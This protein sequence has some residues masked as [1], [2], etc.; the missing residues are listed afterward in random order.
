MAIQQPAVTGL[1]LLLVMWLQDEEIRSST[2]RKAEADAEKQERIYFLQFAD[3]LTLLLGLL[4][5]PG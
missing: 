1:P 3:G 4:G 2:G 5:L